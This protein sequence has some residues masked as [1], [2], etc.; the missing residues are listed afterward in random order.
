MAA[1]AKEPPT[2]IPKRASRFAASLWA[3]S[4]GERIRLLIDP[5]PQTASDFI[6]A[7]IESV[8]VEDLAYFIET[9]QDIIPV[10]YEWLELDNGIVRPWARS[11]VRIWWPQIFE[12]AMNP[13]QM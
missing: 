8:G 10:L 6:R 5:S 4:V 11:V 9:D 2:R 12:A 7:G 1:P 13:R 3:K